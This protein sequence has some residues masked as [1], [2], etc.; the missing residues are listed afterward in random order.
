[1]RIHTLHFASILLE[2]FIFTEFWTHGIQQR[3]SLVTRPRCSWN[4]HLYQCVSL[5][6]WRQGASAST[7][8]KSSAILSWNASGRFFDPFSN[9]ISNKRIWKPKKEQLIESQQWFQDSQHQH[10]GAKILWM[11]FPFSTAIRPGAFPFTTPSPGISHL[12]KHETTTTAACSLW[13]CTWHCQ[14]A[15]RLHQSLA[16]GT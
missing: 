16:K 14:C 15:L 3:P 6:C 4:F 5:E 13:R 12:Q 8:L 11:I 1:M 9:T 10:V 7:T 2:F